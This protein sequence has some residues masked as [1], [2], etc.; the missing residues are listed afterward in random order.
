M[1]I[2]LAV[3]TLYLAT[4]CSM[5]LVVQR[6]SYGVVG[7][8]IALALSYLAI[9]ARIE[10]KPKLMAELYFKKLYQHRFIHM[11]LLA[12]IPIA[13]SW[14]MNG[15][16]E[17]SLSPASY[18]KKESLVSQNLCTATRSTVE[19]SADTYRVTQNKFNMGIAT[20]EELKG[21]AS[22]LKIFGDAHKE[23]QQKAIARKNVIAENLLRLG[24]PQHV[25]A[26]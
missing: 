3:F 15:E 1:L 26:Y 9:T 20:V 12:I 5:L 18:W 8:S 6:S 24:L 10:H 17:A 2:E 23:C 11:G 4:V 25:P 21:S 13:F 19:I 7:V 16:I 22:V 14:A